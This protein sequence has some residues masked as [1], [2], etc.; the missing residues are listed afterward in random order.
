MENKTKKEQI[1]F[2]CTTEFRRKIEEEAK[3]E[4]RTLS[5]YIQLALLEKI[6]RDNK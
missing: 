2:R 3:K 5:N 4:H 1:A 6:E